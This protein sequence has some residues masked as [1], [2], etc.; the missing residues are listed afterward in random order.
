MYKL[1]AKLICLILAAMLTL[2]GCG[3]SSS[4]NDD[5]TPPPPPTTNPPGDDGDDDEDEEEPEP[6]PVPA[7]ELDFEHLYELAAF[8]IGVSVS[9]PGETTNNILGTS[10]R[11][12]AE[13]EVIE[14]HFNQL[15]AGNI[16]K[17]SYL[18]NQWGNYTYNNA[19]Q[20]VDYAA[21]NG[22]TM[23]GHALVWHSCYQVPSW[24]KSFEGDAETFLDQLATHT[25][26]IA[27]EYAGKV[28]SWDVVN[29]A[30]Q[31][32]NHGYR[33][34]AVS[35]ESDGN[36]SLFY[37][38]AEGP[39]YIETA[40]RA[41][42]AGDPSADLYYNDFNLSPN[43]EKLEHVLEMVDDFQ[44]REV[45][46]DGIG[47]QMH[48][49]VS[50]P[51]ISSIKQAFEQVVERDLKV[52]ITELDVATYNPY[53]NESFV[54]YTQEVADGQK[55]RYCEIM[56]AYMEVVPPE[57]RGGFTVWGLTDDSTWLNTLGHFESGNPWPLLFDKDLEPKPAIMGVADALRDKPCS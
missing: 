56:E 14:Q 20:L 55:K 48:I 34:G 43:E 38:H 25:E 32:G 33:V 40:F 46:I 11:R 16:M 57:L 17:M 31:D 39:E 52:K 44:K 3:S 18:H 23:H 45:P 10:A 51:S 15:T 50:W 37:Q 12:T 2:A 21:D 19:N 22:M 42:R 54:E 9:G 24:V 26:T 29:E 4:S 53:G 47:F 8:P 41:A 49:Y 27:A 30:F 28:A 6:E 5:P 7:A 35:C 1:S 13:R 36:V